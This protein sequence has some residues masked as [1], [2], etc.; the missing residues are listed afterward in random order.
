[1]KRNLKLLFSRSRLE[2]KSGNDSASASPPQLLRSDS[3]EAR[4]SAEAMAAAFDLFE[5]DIGRVAGALG[6]DIRA[7][8]QQSQLAG[9]KLDAVHGAVVGLVESSRQIDSEIGGI[10]GS[11]G[12]LS[13]AASEIEFKV[14]DVQNRTATTL[15]SAEHS[16]AEIEKLGRAVSDIG[17]LLNSISEVA[18]RTN[19]LA[20]NATIEAARAG[21]AGKGFAVVA[22]EVK[23][24]SVAAG[25]SVTAIRE[26]MALLDQASRASVA[27]M[28]NI[29][30]EIG[31]L[32]PVC[33]LIA[34]AARGQRE[35]IDGLSNRMQGIRA[36]V[37]EAASSIHSVGTM[38]DEALEISRHASSLS[39]QAAT[40][41]G[42]LGRRVVTLLRSI[43]AADRR[44]SE[45]LPIDLPIRLKIGTRIIACRSFDI[46]EGGILIKPQDDLKADRPA[47]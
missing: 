41:A 5:R 45:R 12:A 28:Y 39:D 24:L 21:E 16:T 8:R 22:G 20:L 18:S 23:A 34:S 30:D 33:D 42:D 14:S 27:S 1:M 36:S 9:Q 13:A 10:A 40:E 38:A 26:H 35:T 3:D 19:L 4:L 6:Q 15:A 46:S 2:E 47:I 43:P 32:G 11:T 31:G 7:A 44:V 25:N 29:R 37:S 17:V